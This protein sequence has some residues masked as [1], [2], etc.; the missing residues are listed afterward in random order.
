[1]IVTGFKQGG[2]QTK[3]YVYMCIPTQT[4]SIVENERENL[5]KVF[6]IIVSFR[7]IL[8]VI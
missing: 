2:E 1:V 6:L 5:K 7:I 4:Q 3:N 8:S